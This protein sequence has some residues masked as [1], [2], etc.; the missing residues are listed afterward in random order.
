MFEFTNIAYAQ[1]NGAAPQ[2]GSGIVSFI[3]II[4]MVVIFYLL[5]IRPQQKREK[6]RKALIAAI[7]AGDKVITTSGIYGVVSSVKD[8]DI[9]VLKIADKTNVEFNKAAIQGKVTE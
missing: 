6:E 9:V 3:P 5:L 2:S 4:L 7:K 8:N 1:T